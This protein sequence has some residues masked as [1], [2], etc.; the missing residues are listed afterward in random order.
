MED[1]ET[2]SVQQNFDQEQFNDVV[3]IVVSETRAKAAERVTEDK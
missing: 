1:H 2:K 3:D